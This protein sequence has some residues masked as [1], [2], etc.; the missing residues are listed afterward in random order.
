[1]TNYCPTIHISSIFIWYVEYSASEKH[2]PLKV[3]A[4]SSKLTL[5]GGSQFD[6]DLRFPGAARSG[7]ALFRTTGFTRRFYFCINRALFESKHGV[8]FQETGNSITDNRRCFLRKVI[9]VQHVRPLWYTKR[10][11]LSLVDGF[12][13]ISR[14]LR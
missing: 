8:G 5:T 4:R 10:W 6:E 11:K 14:D 3:N 12:Y 13:I 2:P 1:M 7:K 9:R